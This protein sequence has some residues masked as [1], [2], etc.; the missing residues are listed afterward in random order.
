MSKLQELIDRLCPDGVPH[1]KFG[2]VL[3]FRRGQTITEKDSTPGEYPVIAGG[4]KPAYYHNEYNRIGETIAVAGSGA[5]A[6]FVSWWTTPIFL[7]DAFSV[8]PKSSNLLPKYVYYCMVN[9]Q[10]QIHNTKKGS[11]VPHVHGSSIA[12]FVI[13]VPPIEVQE[14]IVKILDR[15]ADY[16]AELQAELQARKEQYEYYRNLLLTFNPTACGCGT[17]GEQEINVTTWGGHSYEIIWKTMGEIG[18]FI[19]GNGLQ[20]KDFT[21]S[22]VGCIHYG[23]IYTHYGTF[24]TE[25]KSFVS[26][27]FAKKLRKAKYGDL[28]IATT[29]ENVEDVG[30]AVAWLGDAEIAISGDS[31]VF[32]HKQNP[33]FIAY[34]LQTHRFLQ[35]KRM[36]VSGTKVT[37]I[38]G[39]SLEKYV[40]PIPPLELQ[41]KIVA[42][43]D[44]FETL[45]NDLTQGLPA[46][47]AAVKEQYEYYR[48]KLLTFK[49]IA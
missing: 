9:M 7:S 19:R 25:T 45:V 6:G 21:D 4:Q 8:H 42:I 39:E 17:D 22:G 46:E 26:R 11:G 18:K 31:Y 5:Y 43:L 1:A 24:A 28:I 15:F 44:R 33:K 20:K 35:F 49:R 10:Q 16:A 32:S 40:I 36:N 27:D 29:S 37:R 12:K 47:I 30:K 3:E 38:S 41:E 48:N 23:Q 34:L 2:D 13:P 14:E